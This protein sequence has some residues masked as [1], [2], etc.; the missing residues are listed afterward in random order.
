[1]RYLAAVHVDNAFYDREAE[2]GRALAP[3]WLR[4]QPLEATEQPAD[5]LGRQ[6]C[7]VVG[8]VDQHLAVATGDAQH[9]LTSDRR[10]FDGVADQVVDRLTH[11]V[12]VTHRYLFGGRGHGD[13][14][15]LVR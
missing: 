13:V 15:L 10:V 1:G 14:L 8:H 4:R 9:D 7:T 3:R 12:G 2:T 5:V 6:A 11:A